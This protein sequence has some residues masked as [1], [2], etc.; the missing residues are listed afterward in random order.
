MPFV[1][2]RQPVSVVIE[3]GRTLVRSGQGAPVLVLPPL[4]VVDP[5]VAHGLPR[6]V[7]MGDMH[8]ELHRAVGRQNAGAV[9]RRTLDEVLAQIDDAHPV[10]QLR[11][12]VDRR[13]VAKR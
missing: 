13:E 2:R 12:T 4:G 6:P 5:H 1:E 7:G 11:E 10:Q 3:V 8:G 9:A